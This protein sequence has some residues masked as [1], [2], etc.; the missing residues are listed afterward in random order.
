[1]LTPVV[2][3]RAKRHFHFGQIQRRSKEAV[4]VALGIDENNI[5]TVVHLITAIL[6]SDLTEGR[7][8]P[9]CKTENIGKI[10]RY[11][12]ELGVKIGHISRELLYRVSR[13]IYRD[14]DHI[15]GSRF[16]ALQAAFEQPF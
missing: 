15:G 9:T 8:K 7:I 4:K 2:L 14:H 1:M 3:G 12:Q 5:S 11:T 16:G 13:R 10:P 6:H